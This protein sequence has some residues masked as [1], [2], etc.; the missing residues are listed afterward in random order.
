MFMLV[1]SHASQAKRHKIAEDSEETNQWNDQSEPE[2]FFLKSFPLC[3]C[4][5]VCILLDP[6]VS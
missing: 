5:Y 1:N 3:M 6:I 2:C 4:V